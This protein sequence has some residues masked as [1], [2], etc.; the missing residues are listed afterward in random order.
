MRITMYQTYV[1]PARVAMPDTTSKIQVICCSIC[2][3]DSTSIRIYVPTFRSKKALEKS[4]PMLLL[5]YPPELIPELLHVLMPDIFP[6]ILPK[7]LHDIFPYFF[8]NVL[9]KVQKIPKVL[10]FTQGTKIDP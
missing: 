9:P 1:N 5:D 3:S 10:K 6:E 7:R 4:L 8:S 2:P